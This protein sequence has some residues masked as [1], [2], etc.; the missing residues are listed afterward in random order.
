MDSLNLPGVLSRVR[1]PHG[2]RRW[3]YYAQDAVP[4]FPAPARIA[5]SLQAGV[6]H[7]ENNLPLFMFELL[8]ENA[9]EQTLLSR[10]LW[11]RP[12]HRYFKLDQLVTLAGKQTAQVASGNPFVAVDPVVPTQVISA[13][14]GDSVELENSVTGERFTLKFS[15]IDPSGNQAVLVPFAGQTPPPDG[16]DYWVRFTLDC[17]Q[18]DL[19]LTHVLD[20][21]NANPQ[22]IVGRIGLVFYTDAAPVIDIYDAVPIRALTGFPTR[23]TYPIAA[24]R[25]AIF[26]TA[27]TQVL[28]LFSI[29]TARVPDEVFIRFENPALFPIR[30]SQFGLYVGD[31]VN[32]ETPLR[33][34]LL[35]PQAPNASVVNTNPP[36]DPL[37]WW[38][39]TGDMVM[40]RAG[41][42]CPAGYEQ[43]AQ[44]DSAYNAHF[45]R[46]EAGAQ[47]DQVA[48]INFT[49]VFAGGATTFTGSLPPPV[50]THSLAGPQNNTSTF[51]LLVVRDGRR[52]SIRI[53]DCNFSSAGVIT[54]VLSGD[55][56]YLINTSG[57]VQG[58][59][60]M[61]GLILRGAGS[62]IGTYQKPFLDG[63]DI[64][65]TPWSFVDDAAVGVANGLSLAADDQK[66]MLYRVSVENAAFVQVG[67]VLSFRDAN[68]ALLPSLGAGFSSSRAEAPPSTEF[69][70]EFRVSAVDVAE[71]WIE[72]TGLGGG[73]ADLTAYVADIAAGDT[74]PATPLN[75]FFRITLGS[76]EHTHQVGESEDQ[77]IKSYNDGGHWVTSDEHYHTIAPEAVTPP[78][79]RALI[80]VRL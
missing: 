74:A 13:M 5:Q 65:A 48:L 46:H 35:V 57:F 70:P 49:A 67:D 32:V 36:Q 20:T 41:E 53:A 30:I 60:F 14:I 54:F 51:E 79:A 3:G 77:E 4:V 62:E 55:F 26:N 73:P 44:V 23:T 25:F 68:G 75:N 33:P 22:R 66:A 19:T 29:H 39:K 15:E 43:V 21:V 58:Y 31:F 27:Y 45:V 64:E 11:Q 50:A 6:I 17:F 80:C 78:Y 52:F 12:A 34:N 76:V 16:V 9:L 71:G 69:G 72:V 59:L 63:V 7:A 37:D 18:L 28:E 38:S 47:I 24:D 61:S 56:R 10:D 1:N 42:T 2:V 40:V 8:P